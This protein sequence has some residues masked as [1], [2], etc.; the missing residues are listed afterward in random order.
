[1]KLQSRKIEVVA[2]T[3]LIYKYDSMKQA[4]CFEGQSLGRNTAPRPMLTSHSS[5]LG[6]QRSKL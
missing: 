5:R 2:N 1:M 3:H 4:H 6:K